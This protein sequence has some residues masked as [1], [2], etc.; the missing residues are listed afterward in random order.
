MPVDRELGAVESMSISSDGKT[1][2]DFKFLDKIPPVAAAVYRMSG[3][4][5]LLP[6][7]ELMEDNVDDM[8]ALQIRCHGLD[9]R[10]CF[11][12]SYIFLTA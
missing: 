5:C 4:K 10:V 6:G 2:E 7:Q 12:N 3:L 8:I 9:E 1:L 11:L